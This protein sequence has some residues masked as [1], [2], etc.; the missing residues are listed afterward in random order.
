MDR[1]KRAER[2]VVDESSGLDTDKIGQML[3][4]VMPRIFGKKDEKKLIEEISFNREKESNWEIEKKA[5]QAGFINSE[6]LVYLGYDV[7]MKVEITEQHV[8]V[9]EIQ[10][11]DVSDKDI[12]I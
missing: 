8:K 5:Q 6:N 12:F 3:D 10:G 4:E 2:Q 11:V 7:E 9:L 1:G